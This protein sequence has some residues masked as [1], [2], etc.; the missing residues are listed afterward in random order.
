MGRSEV[1]FLQPLPDAYA[2][3]STHHLDRNKKEASTFFD[4]HEGEASN[5]LSECFEISY[6]PQF[7]EQ[8]LL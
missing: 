1:G 3:R 5:N 4:M 8:I 7:S 6:S 2:P